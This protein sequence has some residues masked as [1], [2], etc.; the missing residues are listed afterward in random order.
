MKLSTTILS[1]T[2]LAGALALAG[3]GGS[4][5]GGSGGMDEMTLEEKLA[6]AEKEAEDAKAK[7][8]AEKKRQADEKAAADAEAMAAMAKKLFGYLTD[9]PGE[10]ET[11]AGNVG[12]TRY[13]SA[14]A[15]KAMSDMF[16]NHNTKE[17]MDTDTSGR[18]IHVMQY[19]NKMSDGKR[20]PDKNVEE[21]GST[22]AKMIM[23][24]VF[25]SNAPKKHEPTEGVFKT[26]GT[27][28]DAPGEYRCTGATADACLSRAAGGGGIELIGDWLFDPDAGA[29]ETKQDEKYATFGWWLDEAVDGAP[30]ARTFSYVEEGDSPSAVNTVTGS[31]TYKGIA[32]GKA[33]LNAAR[34]TDNI[35]GAFTADA[36]LKATFSSEPKLEG[37]ISGFMIDGQSR[38][39]AVKLNS[40]VLNPTGGMDDPTGKTVWTIDGVKSAPS[41][42]W[43]AQLYDQGAAISSGGDTIAQQPQGV[44]GGFNSKF[45]SDGRM[46]GAFG[47]EQ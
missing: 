10:H 45:G 5:D 1:A 13:G 47:A 40:Q 6:A 18:V 24:S 44:T 36:T 21:F 33:A 15:A 8:E 25:S 42:G 34:G 19:D 35:G 27:Y 43:E 17:F 23:A 4:S 11:T 7:Y 31:A 16:M 29:M 14:Q 41:G 2:L 22:N 30:K 26:R 12:G 9:T 37:E 38:D 46:V 28:N 32:V 39:W 3:C 20:P